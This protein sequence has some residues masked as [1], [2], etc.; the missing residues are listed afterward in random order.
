MLINFDSLKGFW[1]GL[2]VYISDK[3]QDSRGDW[4]QNNPEA[5]DYIK[6]RPFYSESNVTDAIIFSQSD[7]ECIYNS[8]D[9]VCVGVA[10]GPILVEDTDYH[11]TFDGVEYR[12]RSILSGNSV[13]IGNAGAFNVSG[14]SDTG[15]PFMLR[16]DSDQFDVITFDTQTTSHNISITQSETITTVK[17]IDNKFIPAMDYVSYAQEQNLTDEQKYRARENIGAGTGNYDDLLNRPTCIS[18]LEIDVIGRGASFILNNNSWE[19]IREISDAGIAKNVWSVG[20][21]KAIHLSG[22]MGTVELDTTLWAYILGFDHNKDLEGSG[23][24]F[25]GF[26][27]DVGANGVDVCLVDNLY[28]SQCMNAV[29]YFSL[30]HWG[31]GSKGGWA[32]CDLRYDVLGSTDIAP[33][34]Y[35]VEGRIRGMIGYDPSAT[36]ATNPVSNTLMS[37]LPEDLRTVM[38]PITKYTDNIGDGSDEVETN[39]SATIDYLPLLAEF[40]IFGSCSY[41]NSYEQNYQVQYEYFAI[42]NSKVKYKHS[43]TG[44]VAYWWERSCDGGGGGFCVTTGHGAAYSRSAVY[45]YGI[46]PVFMV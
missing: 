12:C 9:G 37:C 38:K 24:Q 18:D 42:G 10:D 33:Q 31:G 1:N 13:L 3:I 27:A 43:D 5:D 22:T 2:K 21:C 40:E 46:S 25:G 20:D 7:I 16:Y 39:I 15:E 44:S 34:D 23:I 11:V 29:K 26:K 17:K 4:N 41:A 32:R 28:S 19:K 14:F 6:N 30:N 35:G 8:N 36:C 45:S